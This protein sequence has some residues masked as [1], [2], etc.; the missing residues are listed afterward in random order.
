L[1]V[2]SALN[3]GATEI[4][5]LDL[6]D[7][8]DMSYVGDGVRGFVDRMIYS[9]ETRQKNLELEL[10]KARGIPLLYI[11]LSGE[12]QIPIWDFQY[13]DELIARGYDLTRQVISS[14]RITHPILANVK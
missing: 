10:A 1:P 9:V 7:P 2:E 6:I 8:R 13:T 12:R 4:V 11:G 5:A 3:I 14:E